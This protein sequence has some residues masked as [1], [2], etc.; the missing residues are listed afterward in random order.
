MRLHLCSKWFPVAGSVAAILLSIASGAAVE[1]QPLR[2]HVPEAVATAPALGDVPAEKE[3][4]LAFAL[5]LRN[6]AGLKKLLTDLYDPS[7]PK[8]RQFLS[9]DQFTGAFGPAAA[10]YE[11]LAAFAQANGLRITARHANRMLLDVAGSAAAVEKALH[12][13]LR[14]YQHPKGTGTFFAP[15]VEPSLDLEVPVLSIDGLSDLE[16]PHPA[17]L[18]RMPIPADGIIPEGG[19]GPGGLYRGNDFRHAYATGVALN[20]AGQMLGLLEFDYYH[21]NDIANYRSQSGIATVPLIDVFMDGATAVAGVN[22]IEVALD[23]EV[24]NA[25]APGLTAIIIYDAGSGGIGNDILNRMATDNLAKQLSASWSFPCN[26]ATDQILQQFAAQGQ[27]YFN[28]SGDRGAYPGAISAP[29]DRP[30]VTSVG[31][32]TLTTSGTGGPWVSETAWNWNSTGAGTNATSGGISTVYSIPVWQHGIASMATNGGSAAMRNIPDVAMVAD[33]TYVVYDNGSSGG[34]GGTSV[35]SPLWAAFMALINQQ[36]ASFIRPA[37]GFLNPAVYAIGNGPGYSTNFHDVTTGNNTNSSSPSRFYAT[38]SY[39]LCTG[40]GTPNGPSLINTLAPRQNA[41]VV[42]NAGTA[43]VAEGCGPANGAIDPGETVTL[44]FSLKNIGGVKVTNLVATLLT[45]SGVLPLSAPQTYGAMNSGA[46]AVAR[47][48]TFTANGDCGTS[49][50]ATLQLQDGGTYL[51]TLSFPFAL[52]KPIVLL[53]QNFDSVT[54]PA[55]PSGWTTATTGGG[56]PWATS[57]GPRDTAP[58]A[59]FAAESTSAGITELLSP[60]LAINSSSAQLSFKHNFNFETDPALLTNAY[61]GGVLEIKIG[62]G[63]FLDILAAGGSFVTNGYNRTISTTNADDPLTGRRVWSGLSA[64]FITTLVNLPAAAAGQPVQLKWRFG[65][66]IGNSY[67][68]SGWYIDSIGLQDGYTC[69]SARADLAI[70]HLPAPNPVILGNNLTYTLSVSNL[71]PAGASSVTLTDTLP[72]SV[73][74]VSATGGGNNQGSMVTWD[75]GALSAGTGTNFSIIVTPLSAG[76]FTNTVT[77][78]SSTPDPSSANNSAAQTVA[79]MVPPVLNDPSVSAS[80]VSASVNTLTGVGYQLQ[81]KNQLTDP[82]WI[83]I[84]PVVPGTGG[85]IVLQD[86]NP[87]VGAS[88][89]YRLNC[90]N[91][92]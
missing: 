58:N 41:P 26:A 91:G 48:F 18:T 54:A 23:I 50:N 79:V 27:S 74:F 49:I 45:N 20:G 25:M 30:F 89:F 80:S 43:I 6:Q 64:D 2:G 28:S 42:V 17:G 90:L 11:A 32:T 16:M 87:P 78:S 86:S 47:S 1:R 77:L 81:Y 70:S 75:A 4:R 31:G 44:N 84:G 34:V 9:P 53:T 67:G 35:S 62:G 8:Y 36:A 40:W 10:D 63:S 13:H 14:I 46:T 73:N 57:S 22:N 56:T 88:R 66:D 68:G 39:D 76:L 29:A 24:A 60:T 61:D 3:M 82:D 5:P 12:L 92:F 71:G 83:P 21:T 69:C 38:A 19:S 7:S 59:A 51:G 55:L 37:I 65:T 15:D 85:V 72:A 33:G 52:G